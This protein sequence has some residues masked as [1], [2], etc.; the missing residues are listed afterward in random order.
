[1]SITF[2]GES[3]QYRAARDRLLER[4]IELRRATEA[5]AAARRELP[6]GGVLPEEL[7]VVR[8]EVAAADG[9]PSGQRG[10][11]GV[12]RSPRPQHRSPAGQYFCQLRASPPME[13]ACQ[14]GTSEPRT[15][16]DRLRATTW[17]EP[18]EAA[19]TDVFQ[20]DEAIR[21]PQEMAGA[22][23]VALV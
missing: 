15:D 21:F 20:V 23:Q 7:R 13:G 18:F 16:P 10:V 11:R 1:M 3:P 9:E 6:A 4:E 5:V 8:G 14:S 19:L 22:L 12:V 2:P 17:Q